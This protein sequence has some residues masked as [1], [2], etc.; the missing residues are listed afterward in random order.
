[1]RTALFDELEHCAARAH[2]VKLKDSFLDYLIR[3]KML[4]IMYGRE[5]ASMLRLSIIK[6][7]KFFV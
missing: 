4:F 7:I 2:R 1:M 6:F 3:C 5:R